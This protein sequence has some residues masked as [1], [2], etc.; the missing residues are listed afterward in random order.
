M[1]RYTGGVA[2]A[3]EGDYLVS[4]FSASHWN[5]P[6]IA[7]RL[8][9]KYRDHTPLPRR[10]QRPV[11]LVHFTDVYVAVH[12]RRFPAP[13][14]TTIHDFITLD[15]VGWW[16]PGLG[17]WRSIFLHSLR[18][19]SLVQVVVTPSTHT[20]KRLVER[21]GF[22]SG[23]VH[24]VP[25]LVPAEIRPSDGEGTAQRPGTILS[26][27]TTAGYKNLSLLLH[28][29]A[30]PSL[31]GAQ[32]V[33]VGDPLTSD[34]MQLASRL[35][36]DHRIHQAGHVSDEVLHRVFHEAT[37]LAQPSLAEGFGMPVA[38]AMA[39]GLPV[40]VSDGGALPEVVGGAGRIVPLQSHKPGPVNLDDARRFAS[41][42]SEVL[43]DAELRKQMRSKG[44]DES[45]RF[46]MPAVRAG[47]LDAY[48]EA[49]IAYG[50]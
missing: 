9:S 25:V 30:D 31:R 8:S 38:E 26:I 37:V 48:A 23:N 19:L 18:S 22:A 17:Y 45:E 16:P 14:V 6:R 27:G 11:D 46:R 24:V 36:V 29:M 5:P 39:S 40:V 4:K 47:L 15:F 50:S 3:I 49:T 13:R 43:S 44:L 21:T 7:A 28:A 10:W 1:L 20:K 33:R 12:A 2:R 41:A 35:G 42:L 32:L 34:L